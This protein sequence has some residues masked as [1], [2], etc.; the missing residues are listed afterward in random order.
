LT[1]IKLAG[2]VAEEVVFE[3]GAPGA[4]AMEMF[5]VLSQ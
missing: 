1:G 2:V 3:F 4:L 5:T